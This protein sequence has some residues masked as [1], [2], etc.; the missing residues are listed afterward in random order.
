VIDHVTWVYI[1]Q[2]YDA[3]W[4]FS[5][6]SWHFKTQYY[7]LKL[8]VF[9]KLCNFLNWQVRCN[10][11]IIALIYPYVWL[12]GTCNDLPTCGSNSVRGHVV[13]EVRVWKLMPSKTVKELTGWCLKISE[14][15]LKHCIA[16]KDKII[17]H[18]K[19]YNHG[20][21]HKKYVNLYTGNINNYK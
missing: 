16:S 7:K 1:S 21:K 6:E 4:F 15:T 19:S 17:K 10:Y 8:V 3:K 20:W 13:C 2:R 11:V 18:H 12:T 14:F 5:F 9:Q